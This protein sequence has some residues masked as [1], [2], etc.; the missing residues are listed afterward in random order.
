MSMQKEK[1]LIT[2]ACG[3]IGTELT[4]E[5]RLLYG[6]DHVVAADIHIRPP[7]I[8]NYVQ[9]DVLQEEMLDLVVKECGITQIYHLAAM[10]SA[11]G[12]KNLEAAWN[13]NVHSLLS[14][15][16]IAGKRSLSK[17][18]WPS[19][20]AVFGTGSPQY[21]CPQQAPTEPK[22]VYGISKR[23]GEYWCNYYHEKFGVDVRSLRYPG[24]ISYTAQPG[25]G[26]TD[27]AVDI[28]HHALTS[29]EYT[30][31]LAED[32]CLPMMYMQDALRATIELMEA[33]AE[34][35]SVRTSYNLAGL[36][37]APCDLA[38]SI[39]KHMPG[40]KVAYEPDFRDTIAAGWPASIDDEQSRQ[41]WG[42]KPYFNLA[43]MTADM[44]NQLVVQKGIALPVVAEIPAYEFFPHES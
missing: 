8:S 13:L 16:K 9:L 19:S 42:W 38:A 5:L 7:G 25:G 11:K 39:K 36:S 14:V 1:I 21:N 37:F 27:Y 29:G 40:F 31:Y 4:R 2:G 33:P 41:D 32:R 22:T 20:I 23:A 28:Y 44:L 17:V 15:L 24:L 3:Q 34:R 26:T 12:E 43:S 6:Q 30:C 35:L 10:L 18:F